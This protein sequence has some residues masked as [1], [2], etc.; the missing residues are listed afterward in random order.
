QPPEPVPGI[1]DDGDEERKDEDYKKWVERKK[2]L[3][4]ALE[5]AEQK[6]IHRM[7]AELEKIKNEKDKPKEKKAKSTKLRRR[8]KMLF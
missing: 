7:L 5:A 3:E 4:N 2:K 8:P 1:L 6:E